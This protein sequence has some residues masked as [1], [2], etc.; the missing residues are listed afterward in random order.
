MS[1]EHYAAYDAATVAIRGSTTAPA[2][3]SSASPASNTSSRRAE[4]VFGGGRGS[5]APAPPS[6][7][8]QLEDALQPA[9]ELDPLFKGDGQ[10]PLNQDA[11]AQFVGWMG[12]LTMTNGVRC[13]FLR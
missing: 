8:R 7:N 2:S 5:R 6:G 12:E 11:I 9:A 3:A 4:I 13:A 1:P 10:M